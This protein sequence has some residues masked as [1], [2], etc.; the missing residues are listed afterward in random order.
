M[1]MHNKKMWCATPFKRDFDFIDKFD[2]QG[3]NQKNTI[4]L[5][6]LCIARLAIIY[7]II[8]SPNSKPKAC[9][10]DLFMRIYQFLIG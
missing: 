1:H 6:M 10:G 3:I 9:E 8:L 2:M 7:C 4:L 5:L